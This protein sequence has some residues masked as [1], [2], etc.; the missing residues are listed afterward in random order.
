M[1]N[2]SKK[3]TQNLYSWTTEKPTHVVERKALLEQA[4][5]ACLKG[6]GA[7]V[8]LGTR[9]M[10]KSVFLAH[11]Y[12]RITKIEE[13]EAIRFDRPPSSS[14]MMDALVTELI[15]KASGPTGDKI[16][17]AFAKRLRDLQARDKIVEIFEEY[18]TERSGS[19]ERIVLMYDELDAYAEAHRAKAGRDYF[20]ALEAARKKLDRRLFVVVAGGGGMLA[21]KTILGSSIFSRESRTVLEPF[22]RDELIELA[23]P[24]R[25]MRGQELSEDIIDALLSLSGGNLALATYGLQELWEVDEPSLHHLTAA[26]NA[27]FEFHSSFVSSI[28]GAIFGFDKS[29]IPYYVWRH[30][31]DNGGLLAKRDLELLRGKHQ[32]EQ[33]IAHIDIFDMLRASG[34]VRIKGSA[35]NADPIEATL[36]P[37]ILSFEDTDTTRTPA[38]SLQEQL[39][40][41][42]LDVMALVHQWT[43]SFYR[44]GKKATKKTVEEK[45]LVPE[46]NF[47]TVIAVYL[48]AKGWKANLESMSGAGFADIKA[49]HPRFSNEEAIIEVKI[50]PRHIDEIHNQV[51]SYFTRGVKALATLVIG[52]LQD[53]TWKDDYETRCLK[54]KVDGTSTWK[55]LERPWEGYFEALWESRVVEHFLLR[56][57][58]RPSRASTR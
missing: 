23:E 3:K 58:A 49:E 8:L 45:Q 1:M 29:E 43:P 50:W 19:I 36:I 55:Q 17:E 33:K 12:E 52:E 28:R 38:T 4:T 11:L 32:V 25:Q 6:E 44:P 9:G 31:K 21:L 27:F 34:L 18:L 37:S 41:D 30:F 40:N 7:F 16:N 13:F 51:K 39:R 57:P 14:S 20:D 2:R 15:A 53:T 48:H 56:L 42:L 5:N 22:E 54:G 35:R 26:F 24:F 10:G 46:A 47:A